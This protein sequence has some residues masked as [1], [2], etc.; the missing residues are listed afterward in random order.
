MRMW[1]YKMLPFLPQA[2]LLGQ[3]R[4]CCA[5]AQQ[6]AEK[7]DIKHP[8]VKPAINYS[9]IE[10]WQYCVMVKDALEDRMIFVS[11]FTV[12]KLKDRLYLIQSHLSSIPREEFDALISEIEDGKHLPKIFDKW[13]NKTYFDICYWN[14][15]EKYLCGCV[16]E[17]EWFRFCEGGRLFI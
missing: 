9:P 15:Y 13:H 14:L 6:W 8:L 11:P 2:Q 1:H 4:E 16:P 12:A 3:W 7:D 17:M 5:I 10:F